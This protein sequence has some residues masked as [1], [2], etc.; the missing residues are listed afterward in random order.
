MKRGD[1][2]TLMRFGRLLL[3]LALLLGL[4]ACQSSADSDTFGLSAGPVVE[5]PSARNRQI[6]ITEPQALKAL[7]SEQVVVR[8]SGSEIRYLGG[9]RWSDRLPRLVQAKL[10][11]SFENTKKFGGVGKPGEGLAI[12][13]QVVSE[14]RA[15]EIDTAGGDKAVVEISV[16]ILNDRNGTVRAQNVFR[17]SRAVSGTTNADFVEALDGAFADVAADI[18]A[19]TLKA[20]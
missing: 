8:V 12:D 7:D 13:F 19:F 5:G 14:I 20:I 17:G 11:E 9:S 10:V 3:P 15:F 6:L 18:V 2:V 1:G 4:A 16:K